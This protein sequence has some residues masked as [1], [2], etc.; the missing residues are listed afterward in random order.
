MP[1]EI[2]FQ[3]IYFKDLKSKVLF[4]GFYVSLGCQLGKNNFRSAFVHITWI[5][6]A[7]L[8]SLLRDNFPILQRFIVVLVRLYPVPTEHHLLVLSS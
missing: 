3:L 2:G 1:K 4:R 7:S 8:Y 6:W 5:I